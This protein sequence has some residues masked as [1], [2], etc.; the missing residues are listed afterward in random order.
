MPPRKRKPIEA[1]PESVAASPSPSPAPEP[2]P[3]RSEAP[4]STHPS[5]DQ[6][7][8]STSEVPRF[9][10]T[11]FTTYRAS[12]LHV[13]S[14]E[15]LT[16]TRLLVLARRL[17]D[18]LVGDVVRGVQVGLESDA[19]LGRT[20]ALISV[21][22]RWLDASQVLEGRKSRRKGS[23][24]LGNDDSNSSERG[25]RP[26]VLCIELT[27]ENARFGALLLPDL[28][29]D[30]DAS[31]SSSNQP[32]WTWQTE[33]N[34]S[35]AGDVDQSAFLDLPLILF[36]MPVPLKAVL[37]DFL[38]S[39][40]DCRIAPLGLGTRTLVNAWETWLS[41]SPS[42]PGRRAL[43]KDVLL[44]LGFHIGPPEPTPDGKENN[45]N[46]NNEDP[47]S[48]KLEPPQL[49]LK[50]I[51]I[52]IPAREVR[53]FLRMGKGLDDNDSPATAGARKR[54]AGATTVLSDEHQNRRRR[55]L[56]GG[57]DEEGWAWRRENHI[58]DNDAEPTETIPQPFTEALAAYTWHH[59]GLDMFHPGVRVQRVACDGFALSEGRLKVFP[60]PPAPLPPRHDGNEIDEE[61]EGGG[62]GGESAVWKLMK[63]LTRKARGRRKGR[64]AG[65][66]GGWRSDA[67]VRT[68]VQL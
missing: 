1:E 46:N 20:G 66:G 18:T 13:G 10:S 55:K 34:G 35:R 28:S 63:G 40:F 24:E 31:D 3:S 36:R 4:S 44:T 30:E 65:M 51:D 61:G 17:R 39:T 11:T 49:G 7:F 68:M 26:R 54:K 23:P 8:E 60:P 53:R 9:F 6:S 43:S 2:S 21:D 15:A 38:S 50:T 25:G 27:Y 14:K 45:N 62:G 56:A 12:P 19:S 37:L 29:R 41:D 32:S 16:P 67:V 33:G 57:K 64:G 47:S 42:T 59:L 52:S 58:N 22:W 5:A 48:R